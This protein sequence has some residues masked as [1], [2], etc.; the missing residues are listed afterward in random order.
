MLSPQLA[1]VTHCPLWQAWFIAHVPQTPPHPSSPHCLPLHCLAQH[2][3]LKHT[4][5]FVHPQSA[6]QLPQFSPA[7]HTP[8]PQTI[9]SE[10][11]EFAPQTYPVEQPG[12]HWLPQASSPHCFPAHWGAQHAPA[13]VHSWPFVHA[14]SPGQLLQ[15]SPGSQIMFPQYASD[16][17]CPERHED[18]IGHVPHVPPQPSLPHCLPAQSG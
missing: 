8:L 3:L 12:G 5:P 18:P 6:P 4:L 1:W 11:W 14:Q 15:F 9:A 13:A 2:A 10:H 17:H 16:L 7:W